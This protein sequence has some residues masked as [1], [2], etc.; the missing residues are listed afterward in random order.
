[1]KAYKAAQDAAAALPQGRPYMV[2]GTVSAK[3][4]AQEDI[5]ITTMDVV[6]MQ[7]L[8][9]TEEVSSNKDE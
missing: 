6:G 8:P 4:G 2:P 7:Q 3:R 9:E 5:L 1:M